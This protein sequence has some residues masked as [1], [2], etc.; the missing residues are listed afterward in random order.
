MDLYIFRHGETYFSKRKIPYGSQ[1][2]SAKI[3]PE[4]IPVIVR[5]AD[6]L[7]GINTDA[8]FTSP[9]I[10]CIQTTKIVEKVTK[11]KHKVDNNLRDW[12][13]ETETVEDM[14][15]RLKIFYSQ[16]KTTNFSAVSICTHG[17]PINTLIALETKGQASPSDLQ[18]F[19]ETG[20]L[21]I[22]KD[23]KVKYKDFK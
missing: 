18:N 2:E 22:I 23:K 12:N 3:L 15:N 7:Q 16:L 19:P 21:V 17:Y 6:F 9:F 10:R 14:I 20:V 13:P 1:V 8:N 5:L 11:K 4:A